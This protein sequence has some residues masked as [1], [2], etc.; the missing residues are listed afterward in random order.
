[1]DMDYCLSAW[2]MANCRGTWPKAYQGY[3]I[4]V[5]VNF[6]YAEFIGYNFKVLACRHSLKLLVYKQY[7]K[8]SFYVCL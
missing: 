8:N 6:V 7:F 1:M 2:C 4:Y 3:Y 5:N